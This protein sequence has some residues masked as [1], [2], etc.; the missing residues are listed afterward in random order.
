MA[1]NMDLKSKISLLI[2]T[3]ADVFKAKAWTIGTNVFGSTK[4]FISNIKNSFIDKYESL[5]YIE[6]NNLGQKQVCYKHQQKLRERYTITINDVNVTPL[7][8]KSKKSY[9]AKGTIRQYVQELL[10]INF[11][12][13][14]QQKIKINDHERF[15]ILPQLKCCL[16]ST[17]CEEVLVNNFVDLIRNRGFNKYAANFEK[18]LSFSLFLCLL[19][20]FDESK[21]CLSEEQCQYIKS[22]N[23]N[24]KLEKINT[25]D[26]K[27]KFL[28][29]NEY[30]Y[31]EICNK[32]KNNYLNNDFSKFESQIIDFMVLS[33]P[34]ANQEPSYQN[35]SSTKKDEKPADNPSQAS[36][37]THNELNKIICKVKKEI[38]NKRKELKQNIINTRVGNEKKYSDFNNCQC[39]SL[40]I[41]Y[42]CHIFQVKDIKS[43]VENELL[44]ASNEN[45]TKLETIIG[46]HVCYSNNPSNGLLMRHDWHASF[47]KHF[48]GFNYE[49]GSIFIKKDLEDHIAEA[50]GMKIEDIKKIKIKD[51]VLNEEMKN[52]LI[53]RYQF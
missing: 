48:F 43:S 17:N 10:A 6:I 29:D 38:D 28:L 32:I 22:I 7:T 46:K 30:E 3:Y 47:D 19:L 31:N 12:N 1:I 52:F 39:F 5:Q 45:K 40:N 51:D 25:I 53:K 15:Q 24:A 50:F 35:I 36:K 26:S 16:Q 49:D 33:L 21:S 34:I 13:G 42:P 18:N 2:K 44:N 23:V 37:C 27:I 8:W 41:L 9:A 14:S 11:I 20:L 4:Q